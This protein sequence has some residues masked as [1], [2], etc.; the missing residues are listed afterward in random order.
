MTTD[1][2]ITQIPKEL[3]YK[4]IF[5]NSNLNKVLVHDD[6]TYECETDFLHPNET[7]K[8]KKI[9]EEL[10][11]GIV[12]KYYLEEKL[13]IIKVVSDSKGNFVNEEIINSN[14]ETAFEENLN[15]NEHIEVRGLN[16]EFISLMVNEIFRPYGR[17]SSNTLPLNIAKSIILHASHIFKNEPN[18]THLNNEHSNQTITVI[19]D[20]HGQFKNVKGIFHIFGKVS[21]EHVYIFNGD[22]VDRG[23]YSCEITFL[24]YCLKIV[25]PKNIFINRGNHESLIMSTVYGFKRET[26]RKYNNTLFELFQDSFQ[27]LPLCVCVNN[28]YLIMHG[29]LMSNPETSLDEILEVNRFSEPGNVG[30]F[31][32]LLWT[33]PTDETDDLGPSKRGLGFSFGKSITSAFLKFNNLKKIIRSHELKEHGIDYSHDKQLITVFSAPNYCGFHG[34]KGAVLHIKP[35]KGV[36]NILNDDANL[37]FETFI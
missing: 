13:Q 15:A 2:L 22:F 29:G 7:E 34:N 26:L 21:Q 6:G 3:C 27:S 36:K 14:T 32:D 28:D 16:E 11:W 5:N 10:E 35:N 37:E 25:F 20:V 1:Q 23:I 18:M 17:S 8:G 4:K 19:G 31:H 24:L 33:D 30:L 12:E 9:S